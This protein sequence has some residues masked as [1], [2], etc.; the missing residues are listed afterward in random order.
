MPFQKRHQLIDT[1]IREHVTI[2]IEGRSLRLAGQFHH[3]LHGC[4]VTGNNH[5][6]DVDLLAVKIIH[7]FVAPWAAGFYVKSGK[8]HVRHGF[9]AA[10]LYR[11]LIRRSPGYPRSSRIVSMARRQKVSKVS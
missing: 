6:A 3:F 7:G 4:P 10:F 9:Q 2:P 11:K 1:E 8:S 5:G